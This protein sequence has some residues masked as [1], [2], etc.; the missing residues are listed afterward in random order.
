MPPVQIR[1]SGP[2]L[3]ALDALSRRTGLQRS[4]IMR[5]A[6]DEYVRTWCTREEI[7]AAQGQAAVAG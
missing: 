4:E 1:L 5:R 7:D 2:Q 6:I 3:A